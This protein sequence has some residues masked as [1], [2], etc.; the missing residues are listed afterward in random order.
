LSAAGISIREFAKRSGLDDKQVRRGIESGRLAKLSDGTL[1]PA[2]VG[3]DWRKSVRPRAA[4]SPSVRAPVSAQ[5]DVSAPPAADHESPSQAA[6]RII[7]Q[8]GAPY[9]LLEAE[10]IKEN[11]LALL[12]QLE[13]DQKSGQVVSVTEVARAVGQEYAKVRTRLLAIPAE[14]TPR[15]HRLKTAAE[16]QDALQAIIVEALEELTRD[17]DSAVD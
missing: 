11:F 10:R 15:L 2:L 16:M 12:R 17:G 7:A 9:D 13:Y 3:T 4:K 8:S 14:Q 6:E 1:D 5:R